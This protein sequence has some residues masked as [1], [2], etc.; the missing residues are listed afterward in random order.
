[1]MKNILN[2]TNGD[3]TVGVMEKANIPGDFLPWR[4]VLYEG[5]VPDD[6]LLENLSKIRANFI[7]NRN[8]GKPE[9]VKQSFIERNNTFKSF[10]KYKKV[11]LWFEHDLY[12]QLQLLQIL[13]WF[14][15][16][17][18]FKTELT[19]ICVNQYLGMC[20]P[21]E[22]KDLFKHEKP[23]TK[24]QLEV[25][26]NAWAA[27]RSPCPE[28]WQALQKTDTSALPFL[29]G[30]IIRLLEE[31]PN[32]KNGLSRTAQQALR[33]VTQGEKHPVAVLKRYQESEERKFMG[34][35]SF[36]AILGDLLSSTPPL[37]K[38]SDSKKVIIPARPDQE[39][40][41][42]T[43]GTEVLSGERNWHSFVK[44]DRWIGGVHLTPNHSW[45]WDSEARSIV[46][47]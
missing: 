9:T 42:T 2:I 16:N 25:A 20:S 34:D 27:F 35:L 10:D 45:C 17:G 4:D 36:W 41:I 28:R 30:I 13:D 44:L 24:N 18:S 33:I 32:C 3:S 47:N 8:W 5:P 1:M 39:L 37:L 40:T 14:S 46:K 38:S 22:L 23:I 29:A 12:D 21:D 7:I 15:Q 31:Y 6:L 11:I 26:K 43:E 19:L